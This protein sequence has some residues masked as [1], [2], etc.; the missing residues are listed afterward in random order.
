MPQVT[1]LPVP[2]FFCPLPS[3]LHPDWEKVN[4]RSVE[5]LE[6]FG[7]FDS[8]HQYERLVDA[9]VGELVGRVSPRGRTEAIQVVADFYQWLFA[10]DDAY[11]DEGA[12]GTRPDLLV[13]ELARFLRAAEVPGRPLRD[14]ETGYLAALRDL[15][16]RLEE[17]ATPAQLNRWVE[18]LRGYLYF[19]VWEA[20]NRSRGEIPALDDYAV[21]RLQSGAVKATMTLLDVAEGYEL[22][23]ADMDHP[24]TR[25]LTEMACAVVDWDNDIASHHKESLRAGDGQNLRDVLAH[26]HGLSAQ[27]ALERAIAM[28]DRVMCRFLAL[29][30][31]ADAVSSPAERRYTASLG[32][33]IRANL[34]WQV[35][36]N[37]YRN[38]GQ[39]VALASG[40]A[41]RPSD[42]SAEPL[43]VPSVQW[44]WHDDLLR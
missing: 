21:A 38:P 24:R 42:D 37:R 13:V 33:W 29:K 4:L 40:F 36:T 41:A 27:D 15:R 44:W 19:Q 1:P 22:P 17:I 7:L 16:L 20:A 28:R 9:R 18:A 10:F 31:A 25:A 32:D 3:A 6:S 5:W 12:L 8:V 34:D 26:E 23:A 43:P 11:C 39:P 30:E 14:G 2:P 35:S